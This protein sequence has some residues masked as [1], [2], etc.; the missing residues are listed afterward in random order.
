MEDFNVLLDEV[1]E[2]AAG[3]V[4]IEEDLAGVDACVLD[5]AGE[6][7]FDGGE[8]AIVTGALGCAQG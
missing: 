4:A 8:G 3:E 2:V 6:F 5:N 1:F 7:G